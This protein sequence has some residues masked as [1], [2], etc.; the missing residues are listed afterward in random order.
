MQFAGP[1]LD[2][3]ELHGAEGP[4]SLS[5]TIVDK[6]NDTRHALAHDKSYRQ[7]VSSTLAEL[8][9]TVDFFILNLC[10]GHRQAGDMDD[11]CSHA[12]W[13]AAF[14][15]WFICV[16]IVSG[17]AEHDL[18]NRGAF[19]NI[20][21]HVRAGRVH[22]FVIGPPCE[23]WTAIRFLEM[24]GGKGP[25]PLR[26][27]SSLWGLPNLSRREYAQIEIGN[28]LLRCAV[29]LV[30]EVLS[31]GLC[32]LV[33]HPDEPSNPEY[34]AIWKL[35]IVRRMKMHKHARIVSFKQGPLGQASPKP[36]RLLTAN[37]PRLEEY[38][39]SF[40][41]PHFNP[42][43][44]QVRTIE[45]DGSFATAKLKTYPPRLN[46]VIIMS[47]VDRLARTT[48]VAPADRDTAL[49]GIFSSMMARCVDIETTKTDAFSEQKDP[50]YACS[51]HPLA[52]LAS[53]PDREAGRGK[54]F[55]F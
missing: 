48:S 21:L 19:A 51:K 31:V 5:Y 26:S 37:L 50:P 18:T 11:L 10:S 14:R 24:L 46:A 3:G 52:T 39:A 35:Q 22:G 49:K 38:I 9:L 47:F 33:E 44:V 6:P 16:D 43:P 55:A 8:F 23:T 36:T 54:D 27:A 12:T 30:I 15:V 45:A 7:L 17:N 53:W 40:S 4:A 13:P 1:L 28:I 20:L 34:P 42:S 2:I 25:R 41:S 32:G 29:E